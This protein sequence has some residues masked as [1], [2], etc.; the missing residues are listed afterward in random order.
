MPPAAERLAAGRPARDVPNLVGNRALCLD[1]DGF[2]ERDLRAISEPALASTGD[3]VVRVIDEADW[4]LWHD[5]SYNELHP[6]MR[7]VPVGT[8]GVES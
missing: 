5:R 6:S 7:T 2:A 8:L 4:Y 3:S 1:E